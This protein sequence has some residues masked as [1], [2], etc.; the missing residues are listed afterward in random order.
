LIRISLSIALLAAGSA[1]AQTSVPQQLA[2]EGRLA[3][4]DGGG[5]IS[6]QHTIHF[7]I[8]PSLT[9]GTNDLWHDTFPVTVVNGL[10][11]VELGS[12]VVPLPPTLFDGTVRYLE[13]TIDGTDTLAPRQP[14]GSVPYSILSGGVRGGPVNATSY[15]LNGTTVLNSAGRTLLSYTDAGVTSTKTVAGLFCGATATQFSGLITEP[16]GA[17]SYRATKVI[18]EGVCKSPTAHMCTSSEM[19]SSAELGINTFSPVP[20][21]WLTASSSNTTDDC[22]GWTSGTSAHIGVTWG[23][24]A[25]G[26]SCNTPNYVACCD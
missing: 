12:G 18:C 20:V 11:S 3:A 8:W 22:D 4:V 26:E 16:L 2:Y 7:A 24:S 15:Q 25:A 10:Y 6:G 23:S 17:T 14:I 21:L 19:V 5:A 1:L 13:L 9:G